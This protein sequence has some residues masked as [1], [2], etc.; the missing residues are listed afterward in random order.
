MRKVLIVVD[1][2]KDFVD[3]SLGTPEAVEIV[4]RVREKILSYPK[5]NVYA[6]LDTHQENYHESQEGRCLPVPHCIEGTEGWMLVPQLREVLKGAVIVTKPCFGSVTL[7]K[8]LEKEDEKEPISV[9][10]VGLCTDICVIANAILIKSF[11][12]EVPVSVDASCCAGV[13]LAKHEAALEVM[14]S[15]QIEVVNGDSH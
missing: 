2:Q 5:E 3:G 4:D 1:M 11:M 12:P 7:A 9:E 14:R 6:T 10:L 13:T 8:M 15:C